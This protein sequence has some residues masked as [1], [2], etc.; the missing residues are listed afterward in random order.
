METE[1][2]N[3]TYN[4]P[5]EIFDDACILIASQLEEYGFTYSKSQAN[6]KKKDKL[7]T[8]NISFYSSHYN[9]ISE[10]KGH[11]VMEFICTIE[12]KKDI[13]FS[14]NQKELMSEVHHFEIFDNKT[15]TIDF[16]QIEK[17]NE[18]I[19]T[20]FL[21]VVLSIETD[22]NSFLE[23]V[24]N[25]PIARL[26]DYG[27]RFEPK[28]LEIFNREDLQEKYERKMEEFENNRAIDNRIRFKKYIALR[29]ENKDWEQFDIDDL[30][31]TLQ[32]CWT[33]TDFTQFNK[34]YYDDYNV[35]FENVAKKDVSDKADWLINYYILI[36]ACSDYI[37][38]EKLKEKAF[39]ICNRF[40]EIS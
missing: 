19:K 23:K 5:R 14:I 8:Y 20:H 16:K 6:I 3:K 10:E 12:H 37:G 17:S 36:N 11:V 26:D 4:K 25:Q 28:F 38:N 13:I 9:Y 21:P 1:F 39:S 40:L 35:L 32:E 29:F 31:T 24:I 15:K 27:F 2:I 18:F 22:A 30:W 33:K 7:F 34:L